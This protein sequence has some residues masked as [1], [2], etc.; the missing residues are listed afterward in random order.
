MNREAIRSNYTEARQWLEDAV[1]HSLMLLLRDARNEFQRRFPN[2]GQPKH[3]ELRVKEF[4]RIM[5]KLERKGKNWPH[6][7]VYVVC[8]EAKV[9][10]IV[11]DLVAGKL[12]CATP[13]DVSSLAAIF[14]EWT[15]R[16]TD[17]KSEEVFNE[18]TGYRA[19]HIDARIEVPHKDVRLYFPVEIQIKTL[20]QDAWANFDHDEL[21]KPTDEPP[22]VTKQVSRHLADVLFALD[23]IGQTIREERLR[24]RPAPATIGDDE[25]LVTQ[26]T[27]SYLVNQIFKATMSELELQRCVE[28]LKAFGYISIASVDALASDRRVVNVIEVAKAQLRLPGYPTPYEILYFGPLAAREGEEGVA[29]ELR[30]VFALTDLACDACKGPISQ[31][32]KNFNE[33]QTDL[34]DIYFCSRCRLVRLRGCASC[35]KLTESST[36]K[37]CRAK[38]SASDI[39]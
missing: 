32:E 27:L 1:M 30:R 20:L 38:S 9:E 35:A 10:V 28:Q 26:R 24:K 29:V 22:E 31:E 12:V 11:N 33:T 39:V 18:K 14:H 8:D 37:D 2:I 36:C 34:D 4:A 23:K 6:D 17:I 13:S 19:L 7:E 3:P 5:E 16:L 25:T 15:G 21:Y